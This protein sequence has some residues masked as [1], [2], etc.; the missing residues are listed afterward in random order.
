M[1]HPEQIKIFTEVLMGSSWLAAL[2]AV[3][4]YFGDD[5]WLAPT[6]WF[7]ISI[8]VAINAIYFKHCLK[9]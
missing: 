3:F 5:I 9:K 2:L 7:L 6:Q 1:K 4:G 8:F